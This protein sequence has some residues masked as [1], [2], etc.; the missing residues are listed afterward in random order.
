VLVS[1]TLLGDRFWCPDAAREAADAYL[2]S[3]GRLPAER[4]FVR[5]GEWTR[6]VASPWYRGAVDLAGADGDPKLT[7]DERQLAFAQGR[8]LAAIALK[9]AS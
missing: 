1:G 2:V 3:Q 8:R 9:L 6:G 4:A 5:L 7:D